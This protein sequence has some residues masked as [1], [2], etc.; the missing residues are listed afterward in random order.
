MTPRSI[1]AAGFTLGVGILLA[2]C[3]SDS[4]TTS[5]GVPEESR[6]H[7]DRT[8]VAR[9][10]DAYPDYEV[11]ANG[12]PSFQAMAGVPVDTDRW[13]GTVGDAAYRVEV[14][15]NWNGRL[16]M[17]AHGYAGTG[18]E[19]V[20]QMPSALRA[21][22]L[23]QGFAWAASSYS[24]NYY[25]VRAGVEDTNA[26]AAAF[27]TI[28]AEQGRPLDPPTRIYIVG[29]SMGGHVAAAAVEQETIDN[30]NN[31]VTYAGS[32]PMCGVT[33]DTDLFNYFGSYQA[34]AQYYAGVGLHPL[35]DWAAIAPTVSSAL[36]T[37]FTAVPTASGL[38]VRDAVEQLTGGERPIFDQ[39]FANGG[40]QQVVWGTFGGDGTINGILDESVID[41]TGY[42]YQLD[43]DPA[44]STDEAALNAAVQRWDADAN[45]NRGRADGLRWV[46]R[47]NGEFNV[48]VLTLHTLGDMY[49]PFS[50]TQIY[51]R[52]AI[53]RGS[54]DLLVQRAIRAPSHC[55]F[56]VTE[57]VVAFN[58]LVEWVENGTKPA[59][60]D[61]LT[62]AVVA[63][64][65]YGCTFTVDTPVPGE[66]TNTGPVATRQLMPACPAS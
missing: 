47:V 12:R 63:D 66:P 30:A 65:S 44:I 48:P 59:G 15:E 29:H 57:Q 60:D 21:T 33:G 27:A 16:V 35:Q 38:P 32:L 55:D 18:E 50:M 10:F 61:V 11:G 28:A 14:P 41:T 3:G 20:V 39:G 58:D 45:A 31:V 5:S 62:P 9:A 64:P 56:T 7:D 54:D 13:T 6:P 22:L 52:R 26:L 49:V 43:N 46:P 34:I 37:T 8:F 19:L 36:F 1:A 4:T 25:D 42:T 24:S 51:R 23:T 17:Y 40:L 53:D 2:G